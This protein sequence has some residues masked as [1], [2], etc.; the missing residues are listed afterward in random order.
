MKKL[1]F[2]LLTLMLVSGL[3]TANEYQVNPSKPSYSLRKRKKPTPLQDITRTI[4]AKKKKRSQKP[5]KNHK[6]KDER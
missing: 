4:R 6:S 2:A 1:A 3:K 5:E